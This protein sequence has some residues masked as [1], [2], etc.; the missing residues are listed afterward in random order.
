ME[1]PGIWWI[2]MRDDAKH[3]T[4]LK[5]TPHDDHYLAKK[6][7]V[8]NAVIKEAYIRPMGKAKTKT[9]QNRQRKKEN[10][11]IRYTQI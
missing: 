9:K 7:N 5:T 4:M 6:K 10:Y 3:P 11:C 2:E 8:N 1:P